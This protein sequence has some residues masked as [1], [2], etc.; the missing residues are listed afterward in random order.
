MMRV[1]PR[2]VVF[3][4]KTR[5]KSI[6]MH[7]WLCTTAPLLIGSIA[8][9]TIHAAPAAEGC[10][11]KQTAPGSR[12]SLSGASAA[13]TLAIEY[14]P[15]ATA[16]QRPCFACHDGTIARFDAAL[17]DDDVGTISRAGNAAMSVPV[18]IHP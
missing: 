4:I 5:T 16:H 2:L 18:A 1:G 10:I 17:R 7:R 9:G 3:H 13:T 14:R 8:V 6:D 12:T 11:R 15:V